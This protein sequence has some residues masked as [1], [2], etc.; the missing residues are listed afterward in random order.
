MM[1]NI[2]LAQCK[3]RAGLLHA[4]LPNRVRQDAG[5]VTHSDGACFPR[6]MS[7]LRTPALRLFDS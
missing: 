2:S 4:L 7:G 6:C 3:H 5:P 1:F